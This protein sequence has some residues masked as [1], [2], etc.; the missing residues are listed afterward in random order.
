MVHG[1]PANQT[2]PS[3]ETRSLSRSELLRQLNTP[4]YQM[5][6]NTQR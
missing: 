4:S 1:T 3:S 6:E 5:L 2:S